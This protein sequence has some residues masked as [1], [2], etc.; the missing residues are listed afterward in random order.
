M[1]SLIVALLRA[2]QAGLSPVFAGSCRHHPTCSAYAIEAVQRH[3]AVRGL[4]LALRRLVR[5]G[6]FGTSGYDPVP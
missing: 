4:W 2:W 3:G 1:R 5:C 6:P